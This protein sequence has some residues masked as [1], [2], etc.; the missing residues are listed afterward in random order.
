MP[1][2]GIGD[3]PK[4]REDQRFLTDRGGYLDDL[5][6]EDVAHAEVLRWPHAHGPLRRIDAAA[7]R[8]MP[9]VLAV[10]TAAE[11]RWR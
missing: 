5:V 4:Q 3:T 11:A 9:D 10:L 2:G 7:A 8:A 1:R 6:F